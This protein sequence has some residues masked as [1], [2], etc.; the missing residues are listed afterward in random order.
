M[1]IWI[2]VK[3]LDVVG[4][5]GFIGSCFR[6]FFEGFKVS[7][8]GEFSFLSYFDKDF[9]EFSLVV[10]GYLYCEE[11]VFCGSRRVITL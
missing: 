9:F 3:F 4:S 10:F 11:V 6:R 8:V 7:T 5:E 1:F 2:L